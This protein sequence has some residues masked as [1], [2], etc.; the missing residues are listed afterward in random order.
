MQSL[1]H[2]GK[3]KSMRLLGLA[4]PAMFGFKSMLVM[5]I[6]V[7]V[8]P[9][10][11]SQVL[12]V[13]PKWVTNGLTIAGGMLPVLGIALLMHY[14]PVKKYLWAVM[15]GY[16]FSAYLKLPIIGVSILGASA[17]MIAYKR[18][19]EKLEAK[20]AAAQTVTTTANDD[21][22]DDTYDE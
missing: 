1:A 12:K 11:V 13:I 5:A 20:K 19:I 18:G 21:T 4:G 15:T 22:E 16:V 8:G 3:F 6:I 9:E 10:A 7:L 17:A 2:E 14:M